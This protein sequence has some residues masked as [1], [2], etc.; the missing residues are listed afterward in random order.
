MKELRQKYRGK[1]R[2]FIIEDKGL[3]FQRFEEGRFVDELIKWEN[4]G[5]EETVIG[6][7]PTKF[8]MIL[9]VSLLMNLLTLTVPFTLDD[10]PKI[11]GVVIAVFTILTVLLSKKLF[12]KRYEKFLL[13]G[14]SVGFFY[15]GNYQKDVDGFIKILKKERIRYFKNKY[16]NSAIPQTPEFL[17]K[18]SW[19]KD[20]EIITDDEYIKL[21]SP[22]TNPIKGF[23]KRYE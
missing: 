7:L 12:T 3:R 22:N 23:G 4:I 20:E 11:T 1:K 18:L 17:N 14:N 13:G 10:D 6:Y 21:I 16:L 19:L 9:F 5:F 15:F 2:N 8:E